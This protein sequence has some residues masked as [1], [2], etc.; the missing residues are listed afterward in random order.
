MKVVLTGSTG[1]IGSHLKQYLSAQGWSV[2]TIGRGT[3]LDQMISILKEFKPDVVMHLASLFIAEHQ[4]PEVKALIES[5][6]LFGTEVAEAMKVAGIKR[7]INTGT[8]WQHYHD[9]EPACLY[10]ATK[11]A[12]EEILRFYVSAENF[13]VT[14]LKIFDTYGPLDPRPK[15]IPKLLKSFETQAP[16]QMSPGSQRIDFVH[17]QD[18]VR[19]FEVAAKLLI[20]E[21]TENGSMQDYALSGGQVCSLKELIKKLETL[22]GKTLQIEWGARPYR[23]REIMEPWS[24]G[25]TLP[26]WK[27]TISLEDGLR[28]LIKNS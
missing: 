21:K 7:L 16:M 23:K 4:T 15:L 24:K 3:S 2:Q 11:T 14:T 1:F 8:A 5:N 9:T 27:P 26:G 20:A 22:K 12:F 13:K 6:V 25:K 18:I 17:I 19:A 28:E 10:A